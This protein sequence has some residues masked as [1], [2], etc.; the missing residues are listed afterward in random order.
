MNTTLK[1]LSETIA[2]A[3]DVFDARYKDV[4]T[5]LGIMDQALR[6]QGIKANAVTLDCLRLNK[7]IVFLLHDDKPDIVDIAFGNKEGD[8]ESTSEQDLNKMT[9]AKVIRIM[10]DN[11][12][13]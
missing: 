1:K 4:D 5:M 13:Q 11:F 3:N 9:V 7:K 6:K 8:I 10:E 2:E 12:L